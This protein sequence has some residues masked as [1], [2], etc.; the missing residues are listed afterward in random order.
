MTVAKKS[1]V[2]RNVFPW[3]A[4]P[5]PPRKYPEWLERSLEN[6]NIPVPESVI[7][8]NKSATITTPGMPP[9]TL[10]GK[11]APLGSYIVAFEV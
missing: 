6:P 8:A 7:E 10:G 3:V 4:I 9:R 2:Y 1:L 11:P 5:A